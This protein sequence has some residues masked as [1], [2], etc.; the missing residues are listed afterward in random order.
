MGWIK[1]FPT[2]GDPVRLK[3][4]PN[5]AQPEPYTLN[6]RKLSI[7]TFNKRIEVEKKNEKK[8]EE[9]ILV[10]ESS[11]MIRIREV[12]RWQH[13]HDKSLMISCK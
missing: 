2:C 9:D 3:N 8:K 5:L 11:V 1:D 12:L 6:H 10:V 7:A 13:F 4:T